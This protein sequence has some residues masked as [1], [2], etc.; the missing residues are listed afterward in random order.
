MVPL[1]TC[2]GSGNGADVAVKAGEARFGPPASCCSMRV[3]LIPTRTLHGLHRLC[4]RRAWFSRAAL[5]RRALPYGDRP[6]PRGPLRLFPPAPLRPAPVV[7]AG[8]RVQLGVLGWHRTVLRHDHTSRPQAG[9]ASGAPLTRYPGRI[10]PGALLAW[11]KRR[12]ADTIS[13]RKR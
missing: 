6:G 1:K 9:Q 12:M 7:A 8:A 2:I 5:H 13:M 11:L 3:A 10:R 4:L